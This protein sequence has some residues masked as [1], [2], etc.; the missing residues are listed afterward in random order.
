MP[1]EPE[2]DVRVLP[3]LEDADSV[4]WGAWSEGEVR[5]IVETAGGES[6]TEAAGSPLQVCKLN[7]PLQAG[8]GIYVRPRL[9][10]LL[11]PRRDADRPSALCPGRA[12]ARYSRLRAHPP[13]SS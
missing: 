8:V 1:V 2:V 6:A 9:L 3:W 7:D 10:H 5:V 12:R 11:V 4:R 13:T